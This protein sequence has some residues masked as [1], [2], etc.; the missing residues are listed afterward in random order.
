MWGLDVT[1]PINLKASNGYKFILMAIDHFTEWIEANSYIYD[2]K[3]SQE[4]HWEKS[5]LSLFT[6]NIG[7]R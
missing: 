7:N 3:S 6:S 2:T 4:V 5:D 1:K